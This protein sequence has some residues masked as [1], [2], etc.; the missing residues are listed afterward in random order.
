MRVN[1]VTI[2]WMDMVD[3]T[4]RVGNWHM[5]VAGHRIN[6]MGQ[7]RFIMTILFLYYLPLI[8]PIFNCWKTIGNTMKAC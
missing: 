4:I 3:Y 1:G 6:S 2:K 8:T 5:K 7:E